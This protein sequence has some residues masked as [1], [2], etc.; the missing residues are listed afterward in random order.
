MR[1]KKRPKTP[2]VVEESI[3]DDQVW[4]A[5]DDAPDVVAE[6]P[7]SRTGFRRA[8]MEKIAAKTPPSSP[9]GSPPGS[10]AKAGR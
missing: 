10:P 4:N 6:K 1:P 5:A 9:P 2:D 3:Y 7:R 8:K